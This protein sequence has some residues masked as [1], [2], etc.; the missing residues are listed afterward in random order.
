MRASLYLLKKQNGRTE[1]TMK[2]DVQVVVDLDRSKEYPLNFICVLP[3]IIMSPGKNSNLF[4]KTFGNSSLDVARKLIY[5]ALKKEKDSE[6]RKE[7]KKRLNL[8][9]SSLTEKVTTID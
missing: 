1:F 2:T 9:K 7:L 4:G 8:L 6:I 3:Q 5:R